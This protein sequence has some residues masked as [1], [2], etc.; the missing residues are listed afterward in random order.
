MTN[1]QEIR[2]KAIALPV[3]ALAVGEGAGLPP[4]GAEGICGL[5]KAEK[6][7]Y[8]CDQMEGFRLPV[9]VRR[10]DNWIRE[11]QDFRE[12]ILGKLSDRCRN[13]GI[14]FVVS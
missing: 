2:I 7:C 8:N 11:R 6:P 5:D 4:C 13:R 12:V 3:P 9:R 1:G 10:P 14:G